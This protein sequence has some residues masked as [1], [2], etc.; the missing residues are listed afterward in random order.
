M[1]D[2]FAYVNIFTLAVNELAL[3]CGGKGS[4]STFTATGLKFVL[5]IFMYLVFDSVVK[6]LNHLITTSTSYPVI[7]GNIISRC[8]GKFEY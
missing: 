8:K 6:L 1:T 3:H 4:Q 5:L 2:H 7:N